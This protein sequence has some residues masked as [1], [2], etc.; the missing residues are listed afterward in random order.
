MKQQRADTGTDKRN[1]YMQNVLA[2]L[3]VYQNGN[4]NCCAEHGKHVL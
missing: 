1:L 2:K 4:E 3:A